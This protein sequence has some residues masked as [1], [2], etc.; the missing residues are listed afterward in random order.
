MTPI[1]PCP[2]PWKRSFD[3][4]SV[5]GYLQSPAARVDVPMNPYRCKC[6]RWHITPAGAPAP[7][8]RFRGGR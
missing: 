8:R 6:G 1:R 5:Y 3:E 7:Q 4:P 2:T